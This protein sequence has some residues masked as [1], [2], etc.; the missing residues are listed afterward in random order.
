MSGDPTIWDLAM[1]AIE[2]R[3]CDCDGDPEDIAD[4]ACIAGRC[5][6]ALLTERAARDEAREER[7]AAQA[8]ADRLRRTLAVVLGGFTEPSHLGVSGDCLRTGWVQAELVNEW[9][10]LVE[11]ARG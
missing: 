10:E 8:N 7:D 11:V 5:E 4:H 3:G 6:H 1:D 9:R 2:D